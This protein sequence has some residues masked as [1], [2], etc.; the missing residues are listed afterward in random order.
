MCSGSS[1]WKAAT[2]QYK[3]SAQTPLRQVRLEVATCQEMRS[4]QSMKKGLLPLGCRFGCRFRCRSHIFCYWRAPRY[5]VD[6]EAGRPHFAACVKNLGGC[7]TSPL[8]GGFLTEL[9]WDWLC[10]M[11]VVFQASRRLQHLL[12]RHFAW[13]LP[14]CRTHCMPRFQHQVGVY[15]LNSWTLCP[16]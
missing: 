8:L 2:F 13:R 16:N 5:Q 14:K 6:S 1:G 4:T 7:N 15:T 11:K 3:R 12:R 9:N 10:P